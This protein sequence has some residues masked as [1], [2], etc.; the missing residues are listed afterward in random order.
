MMRRDPKELEQRTPQE[1]EEHIKFFMSLPMKEL[2]RRQDLISA[3]Q[4]IAYEN[5][6]IAMHS[7]PNE[8]AKWERVGRNLDQMWQDI[9]E[10]IDRKSF[11]KKRTTDPKTPYIPLQ[12]QETGSQKYYV[13][14]R[15]R[16]RPIHRRENTPPEHKYFDG[17]R[18]ELLN[19]YFEAGEI[20]SY[21]SKQQAERFAKI[22]R[23]SYPGCKARIVKFSDGYAVYG[24]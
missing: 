21:L 7:R 9:F 24:V 10:A 18:F 6:V 13:S 16:V 2:R 3:Q 4:K 5:Y 14:P 12:L 11:P 19:D 20:G 22:W 23:E 8:I 1:R 17:E 15:G